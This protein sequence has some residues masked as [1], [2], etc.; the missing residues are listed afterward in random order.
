M[1][2][3]DRKQVFL[4]SFNTEAATRDVFYSQEFTR[5]SQEKAWTRV[6]L[7]IKL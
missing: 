4:Q 7:I 3:V 6:S 1:E 2:A 5:N